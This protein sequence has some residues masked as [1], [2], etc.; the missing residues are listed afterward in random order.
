VKELF[1]SFPVQ[2]SRVLCIGGITRKE[3]KEASASGIQA[4]SNGWYLFLASESEPTS[5]VEI[6]AQFFSIEQ[7]ERAAEMLPSFA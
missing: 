1:A 6:L 4:D 5:P 2:N 7:A 3:A